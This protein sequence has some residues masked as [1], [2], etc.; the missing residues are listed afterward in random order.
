MQR[1]KKSTFLLP[2]SIFMAM[3]LLQAC[4]D[5]STG[6][7]EREFTP[8]EPYDISQSVHDSTTEDGLEIHVIEEGDGREDVK[9]IPRDQV[10]VRYTGRIIQ[11]NGEIGEV[12]DSSYINDSVTP[13]TLQNLTPGP[14][15]SS[16]GQTISPLIDGFRRGLLGMIEGEKRVLIIPPE[17]GYGDPD[18]NFSGGDLA[19]KTLRFDIELVQIAQ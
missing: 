15:T 12:F 16:Q 19:D 9:V 1:F 17:L 13:R 14:I 7:Y 11:E 10:R 5:S 4:G 6:F 18:E 8:P 3:V 2:L